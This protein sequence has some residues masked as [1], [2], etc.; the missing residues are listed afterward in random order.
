MASSGVQRT[1][2]LLR[3]YRRNTVT[4]HV[5][6]MPQTRCT[7][8]SLKL[9]LQPGIDMR[10]DHPNVLRNPLLPDP[11]GTIIERKHGEW[12]TLSSCL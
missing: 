6:S 5:A 3:T 1:E 9:Y 10:T 8:L 4:S 2:E 12:Y 7:F 11:T